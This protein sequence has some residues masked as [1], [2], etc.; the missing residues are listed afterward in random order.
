MEQHITSSHVHGQK[1]HQA[2]VDMPETKFYLLYQCLN[3]NVHYGFSISPEYTI[4][5]SVL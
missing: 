3:G 2:I 5:Y 1:C 4:F